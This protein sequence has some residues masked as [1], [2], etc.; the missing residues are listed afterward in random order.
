MGPVQRGGKVSSRG[1]ILEWA[2]K[3]FLSVFQ[4]ER[5]PEGAPGCG[6]ETGKKGLRA[7][8]IPFPEK[9][10]NAQNRVTHLP[11]RFGTDYPWG[12]GLEKPAR[13]FKLPFKKASGLL[14]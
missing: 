12:N 11:G 1:G 3:P 9:R 6:K 8:H 7:L 4:K 13:A 5:N 14:L 10:I 2:Q